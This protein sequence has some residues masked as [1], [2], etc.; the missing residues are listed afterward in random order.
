M[1]LGDS[2]SYLNLLFYLPCFNLAQKSCPTFVGCGSNDNNLFRA[3]AV[4]CWLAWLISC[5][6]G[7]DWSLLAL[8]E[9]KEFSLQPLGSG[10]VVWSPQGS[11]K[12]ALVMAGSPGCLWGIGVSALGWRDLSPGQCPRCQASLGRRR[13]FQ[14]W[15]RK[16]ALP[17]AADLRQG[18]PEA[19]FAAAAG[20]NAAYSGRG[21]PSVWVWNEP[22]WALFCC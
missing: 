4:P 5:L 1:M 16:G 17:P 10:K 7:S 20:F 14:A 8:S 22:S 15:G 13:E 6:W 12:A 18:S 9:V 21:T 19:S 3:S 2:G 11:V